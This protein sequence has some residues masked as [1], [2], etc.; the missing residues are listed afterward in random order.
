ML[1]ISW[2]S[3]EFTPG[4]NSHPGWARPGCDFCTRGELQPFYVRTSQNP[5]RDQLLRALQGEAI[6]AARARESMMA[7]T[8][9]IILEWRGSESVIRWEHDGCKDYTATLKA[10]NDGTMSSSFH[11]SP[12]CPRK[13]SSRYHDVFVRRIQRCQCSNSITLIPSCTLNT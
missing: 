7:G 11:V 9:D 4:G 13:R 2:A 10:S 5:T 3:T 8:W 1:S 6:L 12:L